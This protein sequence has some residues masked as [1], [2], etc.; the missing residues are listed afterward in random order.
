VDYSVLI[1]KQILSI[2]EDVE[3]LVYK[4][5]NASMVFAN[6][7]ALKIVAIYAMDIVSI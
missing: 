5:I 6:S 1:R 4:V 2:V 7:I 3:N